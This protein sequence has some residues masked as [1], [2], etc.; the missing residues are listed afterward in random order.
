[1]KRVAEGDERLGPGGCSPSGV[2]RPCGRV[3][4][5]PHNAAY[6]RT[7]PAEYAY[8]VTSGRRESLAGVLREQREVIE[9]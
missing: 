5:D 4:H 2:R 3:C 7:D 9:V 6:E 8:H 1:M